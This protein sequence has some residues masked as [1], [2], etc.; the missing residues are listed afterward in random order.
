MR[1]AENLAVVTD[2]HKYYINNHCE[3]V[4]A[5]SCPNNKNKQSNV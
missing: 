5:F 1:N 4:M 3:V 2:T